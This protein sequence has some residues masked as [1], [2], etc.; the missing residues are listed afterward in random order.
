MDDKERLRKEITKRIEKMCLM[1]DDFMTM[2]LQHKECAQLVLSIILNRND[3]KVTHCKSQY[4]LHSLRG[5]S[6]KLDVYAVDSKGKKYDIE[7]QK[8]N[9]GADPKRARYNSS[10]MDADSLDKNQSP[11]DLPEIYVIFITENDV[12]KKN[13]PVYTIERTISETGDFFGDGSHIIYVN[14]Q[15]QDETALGKLMSDFHNRET[16]NMH[17]PV[18]SE[19]SEFY[20]YGGGQTTMCKLVEDLVVKECEKVKTEAQSEF[21]KTMLR[22]K[23]YTYQEISDITQLSVDRI[24][25][26]DEKLYA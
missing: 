9:E 5:R 1:D 21:V 11:K 3:L 23:K 10:L 7:I 4:D 20:K 25:E 24:K 15:I 26:I 19:Q 8:A 18:L 22:M 14:S 13:K 2:V 16:K 12:L 6:V 17:Y